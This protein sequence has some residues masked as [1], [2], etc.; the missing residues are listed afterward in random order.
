M[1]SSDIICQIKM[2][3][4]LGW[5]FEWNNYLIFDTNGHRST[6]LYDKRDDCNFAIIN[7]T[8]LV[9]N[10]P[11]APAYGVYISQVVRAA[12]TYTLYSDVF[13]V[14]FLISTADK[15]FHVRIAEG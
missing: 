15:L 13:T 10:I 3:R 2:I 5:H 1:I 8:H 11:T 12:R 4:T 7:I 6:R 14:I 9:S